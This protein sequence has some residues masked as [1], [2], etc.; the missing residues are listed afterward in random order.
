MGTEFLLT[1]MARGKDNC[2]RPQGVGHEDAAGMRCFQV[3]LTLQQ[4]PGG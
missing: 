4:L 2:N 3:A 1:M